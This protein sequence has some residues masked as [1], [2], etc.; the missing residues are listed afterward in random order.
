MIASV[1]FA[2]DFTRSSVFVDVPFCFCTGKFIQSSIYPECSLLGGF[3][4]GKVSNVIFLFDGILMEF[5]VRL[6][7]NLMEVPNI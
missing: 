1:H 5:Y 4:F 3:D 6:G 7:V 2:V